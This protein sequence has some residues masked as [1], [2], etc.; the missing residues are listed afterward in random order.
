MI[1]KARRNAE[2]SKVDVNFVQADFKKLP[3]V[4]DRKFD[5][6]VCFGN[7]L[8]HELQEKGIQTALR[9]MYDVLRTTASS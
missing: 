9:S 2:V 3:D 1:N 8:N 6:G 5:C 4:F 7:S